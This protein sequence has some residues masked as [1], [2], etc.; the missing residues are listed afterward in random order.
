M[1]DYAY[2]RVRYDDD[3]RWVE[4]HPRPEQE[5]VFETVRL[6]RMERPPE[7]PI[8]QLDLQSCVDEAAFVAAEQRKMNPP[9]GLFY[10]PFCAL[11][12]TWD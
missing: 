5:P 7:E 6:Q 10:P 12:E 1:E 11:K 9:L 3:A 8:R 2:E 4:R